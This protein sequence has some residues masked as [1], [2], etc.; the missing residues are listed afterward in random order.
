MTVYDHILVYGV[1][2]NWKDVMWA[3]IRYGLEVNGKCLEEFGIT[4]SE[5]YDHRKIHEDE[6]KLVLQEN[7]DED[8]MEP[9]ANLF[10]KPVEGIIKEFLI[11]KKFD[12]KEKSVI[13]EYAY[14]SGIWEDA[15]YGRAEILGFTT[16]DIP[17]DVLEW[18]K[19]E[20]EK[21]HFLLGWTATVGNDLKGSRTNSVEDL[22]T[23]EVVDILEPYFPN[24]P[25]RFYQVQGDCLCCS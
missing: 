24:H 7:F 6:L 8:V 18:D 9:V 14:E 19:N 21:A 13:E 17:H 1:K 25:I 16:V 22:D 23:D 15:K 5:D 2:L 20:D 12:E 11:G 3:M 10:C 4:N